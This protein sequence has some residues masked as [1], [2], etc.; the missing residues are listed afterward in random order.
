MAGRAHYQRHGIVNVDTKRR[1]E[2][3]VQEGRHERGRRHGTVETTLPRGQEP[4]GGGKARTAAG[5]RI[6]R[7]KY[8]YRRDKRIADVLNTSANEIDRNT[9]RQ[10]CPRREKHLRAALDASSGSLNRM[11]PRSTRPPTRW[12]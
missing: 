4:Y 1:N 7:R 11:T 9:A 2:I 5:K 3:P 12:T 8:L 10:T 6:R